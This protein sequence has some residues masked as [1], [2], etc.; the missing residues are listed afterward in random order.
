MRFGPNARPNTAANDKEIRLKA[1]I[2]RHLENLLTA[3]ATG[4]G[5]VTFR[6]LA[7]SAESPAARVVAELAP[8][9]K[10]AGVKI[11]AVFARRTSTASLDGMECRFI[12]DARIRDAHEQLAF[13]STT[14]WIGDCMRRDPQTRETYELYSSCPVA[15]RN[16][17]RSFAQIWRA[18]GPSGSLT[19]EK[20]W[21]GPRQPNLFDPSLIKA[22]EAAPVAALLRH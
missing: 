16:A 6:L 8:I 13:D 21:T 19:D 14:T 20:K 15:G 10:A 11:E 18:A 22:G 5:E 7:L 3:S 4:D 12:T 1:F 17:Q 9:L 2:T